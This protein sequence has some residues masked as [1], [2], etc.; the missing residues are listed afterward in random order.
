MTHICPYCGGKMTK[1]PPEYDMT[2]K[3]GIIYNLIVA[4]GPKGVSVE[5]L[6]AGIFKGKA[7]VSIRS[8][9]YRINQIIKPARIRA[10]HKT[11]FIQA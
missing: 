8:T 4:A 2:I 7:P 6:S 3:Q 1:P 10:H 11:Y 9:V 5:A